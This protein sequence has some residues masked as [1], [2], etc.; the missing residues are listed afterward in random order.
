MLKM[1]YSMGSLRILHSLKKVNSK[2]IN[3]MIHLVELWTVME[4]SKS[5]GFKETVNT[6]MGME[7]KL[8]LKKLTKDFSK[9]VPLRKS[10]IKSWLMMVKMISLHK[11]CCSRLIL[12]LMIVWKTCRCWLK[13]WRKILLKWKNKKDKKFLIFYKKISKKRWSTSL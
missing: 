7:W 6:Y 9:E 12:C 4:Y 2:M 5:V 3:L 1:L 10:K 8:K 13:S 11:R